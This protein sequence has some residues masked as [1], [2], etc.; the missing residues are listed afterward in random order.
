[1]PVDESNPKDLRKL[2]GD[3][4]PGRL[5]REKSAL[6]RAGEFPRNKYT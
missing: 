6:E 2:A 4:I 5:V 1:M 3:E